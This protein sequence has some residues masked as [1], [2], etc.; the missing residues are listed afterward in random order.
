M[1]AAEPFLHHCWCG[2]WGAYGVGVSLRRDRLGKW[3][4]REHLPPPEEYDPKT[5]ALSAS[6]DTRP[7]AMKDLF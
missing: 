3:Y 4:C 5:S 7:A 1:T 2:K 6:T